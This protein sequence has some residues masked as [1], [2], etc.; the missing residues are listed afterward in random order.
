MDFG[1]APSRRS[2]GSF[3]RRPESGRG[4]RRV[5]VASLATDLFSGTADIGRLA[6]ENLTQ[7][8]AQAKHV[9]AAVQIRDVPIGLL[10]LSRIP[11]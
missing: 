8:G 10:R 5:A 9:G 11:M 7:N 3:L 1:Y 4:V 2:L 6:R